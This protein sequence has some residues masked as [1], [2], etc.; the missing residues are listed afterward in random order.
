MR[1]QGKDLAAAFA[2]KQTSFLEL[3]K[4]FW[5]AFGELAKGGTKAPGA[6]LAIKAEAVKVETKA[7]QTPTAVVVKSELRSTRGFRRG[8]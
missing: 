7:E 8:A 2:K 3:P 4:S 6:A 1:Q 5:M